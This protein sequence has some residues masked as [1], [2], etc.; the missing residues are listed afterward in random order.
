LDAKIRKQFGSLADDI[1]GYFASLKFED[2]SDSELVWLLY[3]RFGRELVDTV[4]IPLELNLGQALVAA[5]Q[6]C[7]EEG[8]GNDDTEKRGKEGNANIVL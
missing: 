6:I 1:K 2:L 8:T 3:Q 5:L 4:C 7:R